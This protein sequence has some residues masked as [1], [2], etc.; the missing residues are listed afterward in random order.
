MWRHTPV[1]PSF[2]EV[3]GSCKLEA[4]LGY[5]V[6]PC[7]NKAIPPPRI[8]STNGREGKRILDTSVIP[9]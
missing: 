9:K 6:R 7:P 5:L 2:L 8:N 3:E 1:D 4:S